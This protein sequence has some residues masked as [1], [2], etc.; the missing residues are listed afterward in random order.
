MVLGRFWAFIQPS[1]YNLAAPLHFQPVAVLRSLPA[2]F[3]GG[4]ALAFDLFCLPIGLSL[5]IGW[6]VCFWGVG[7]FNRDRP[8]LLA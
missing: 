4:L 2:R 5:S 7:N 6:G 3:L 8:F 1:R